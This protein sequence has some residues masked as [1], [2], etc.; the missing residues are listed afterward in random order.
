MADHL[1][2]ANRRAIRYIP[3]DALQLSYSIGADKTNALR[4]QMK[5]IDWH[6]DQVRQYY[7]SEL[8]FWRDRLEDDEWAPG[9]PLY[10]LRAKLVR[11]VENE[12]RHL[13]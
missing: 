9:S 11:E 10:K 3:L 7:L 2:V 13:S 1:R 6:E 12:V 8:Q 4:R 5:A